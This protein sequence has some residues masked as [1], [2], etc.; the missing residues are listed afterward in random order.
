[1]GPHVARDLPPF[2]VDALRPS[3]SDFGP[4]PVGSRVDVIVPVEH[5]VLGRDRV[6]LSIKPKQHP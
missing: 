3:S 4:A 6:R 2:A 1:M 5:A